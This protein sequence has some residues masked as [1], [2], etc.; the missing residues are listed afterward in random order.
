MYLPAAHLSWSAGSPEKSIDMR[1]SESGKQKK[2]R[3]KKVERI[4]GWREWLGL[5]DLGIHQVK[6]KIDTGASTSSLHAMRVRAVEIDGVP[7]VRFVV[8][9]AQRRR[10]PEIICTAPIHDRRAVTSSSG[11]REMRYVIRT[12]A[13]IGRLSWPI[14]LT[15]TDRDS[16]GFR[17]LLG[18]QAL[19]RRCTGRAERRLPARSTAT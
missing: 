9:P 12:R 16:M 7:H 19:R 6:A 14:E 2:H 11:H 13:T 8:H 4:I 5:H 18:R 15:L 17:M 3:P 10:D 1:Q